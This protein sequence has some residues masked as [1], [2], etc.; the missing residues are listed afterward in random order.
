MS[1]TDTYRKNYLTNVIARIDFPNPLPIQDSLSLKLTETILKSFPVAEPGTIRSSGVTFDKEKGV[2]VVQDTLDKQWTFYNADRSKNI[3]ITKNFLNMTYNKYETFEP[4]KKDFI[5]IITTLF[6]EYKD[7]LIVSRF[8][9]RYINEIEI[10]EPNPLDWNKYIHDSLI[11]F[12]NF[13][14]DR[15][16]IARGLC[17]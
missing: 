9:L 2:S 5:D 8:G 10:N 6:A 13:S 12:F 1:A 11:C 17:M 7:N 4:F 15:D 3:M 16:T 14:E